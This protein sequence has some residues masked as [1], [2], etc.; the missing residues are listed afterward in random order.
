MCWC[1]RCR[2]ASTSSGSAAR[3]CATSTG[4]GTRATRRSPTRGRRASGSAPASPSSGGGR[5]SAAGP[6]RGPTQ[7]LAEAAELRTHLLEALY[8]R[9][10]SIV[11]AAE[12]LQRS[13]LSDPPEPARPGG[14]RAVRPG[15]ARGPG[16]RRLVRRL[17]PA[18]RVDDAGHRR[19]RRSRH[20]GR[21]VHGPAARAAARHRLRQRRR[22]GRRPDAA[23]TRRSPGCA[24]APSPRC[25]SGGWSRSGRRGTRLRWSSA[26]HLPPL[27]AGPGRRAAAAHRSARPACCSGSIPRSSALSTKSCWSPARRCCSTPTGSSSAATSSST[28]ASSYL[29]AALGEFRDLPLEAMCDALL[30]RVLPSVVQDDVALVAVRLQSPGGLSPSRG[31]GSGA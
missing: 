22:A 13:L 16:R 23:W 26:G 27:V 20:R 11:R 6:S 17:R 14:G 15:R 25:S 31:P 30:A 7:Q 8:A 2:R 1:C 9:S 21:G 10:R 12:T 4:A 24:S 19:R 5:P 29:G 3:S 28:T 18:R